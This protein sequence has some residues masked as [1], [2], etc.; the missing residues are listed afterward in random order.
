MIAAVQELQEPKELDMS[1][2]SASS[3][4]DECRNS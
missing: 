4:E 2:D 3:S 1:D